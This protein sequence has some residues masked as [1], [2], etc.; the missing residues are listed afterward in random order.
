MFDLSHF[1]SMCHS[2]PL[3]IRT[4]TIRI[5][6]TPLTSP[7]MASIAST[8]I[9][10]TTSTASCASH[11]ATPSFQDSLAS[12]LQDPSLHLNPSEIA[13]LENPLAI[14]EIQSIRTQLDA[15]GKLS[16]R[17]GLI[18]R[19]NP[20]HI[21]Y[22]YVT[23]PSKQASS[24][25][26][27]SISRKTDG[28][29]I[30][31][32]PSVFSAIANEFSNNVSWHAHSENETI[33]GDR[34][35]LEA[36]FR[37]ITEKCNHDFPQDKR[38][39]HMR[40]VLKL[41]TQAEGPLSEVDDRRLR[42]TDWALFHSF[43][44][45]NAQHV[46]QQSVSWTTTEPTYQALQVANYTEKFGQGKHSEMFKTV[47]SHVQGLRVT[48]ETKKWELKRF[49]LNVVRRWMHAIYLGGRVA[50]LEKLEDAPRLL[51]PDC[52]EDGLDVTL[53]PELTPKQY[54]AD[55]S[56]QLAQR[57]GEAATELLGREW[58]GEYRSALEDLKARDPSSIISGMQG[59][60]SPGES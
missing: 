5:S 48:L 53:D 17:S 13:K 35:D 59:E 36:N 30:V 16:G 50:L 22:D 32:S 7:S 4:N 52:R 60:E 49:T 15:D 58:M 43:V 41:G 19:P 2:L 55:A 3:T 24:I 26:P 18:F 51:D 33:R 57:W 27:D 28:I 29:S 31:G 21:G 38:L 11:R 6:S 20:F 34:D 25:N 44:V 23:A 56:I 54:Q 10:P 37:A 9:L 46:L 39:E 12:L 47:A 42:D 40:K 14:L 1:P 45:A 8:T